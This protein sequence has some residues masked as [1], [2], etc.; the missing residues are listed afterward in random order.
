[1]ADQ[2]NGGGKRDVEDS[3]PVTE[4]ELQAEK[5]QEQ[6]RVRLRTTFNTQ[7][8]ALLRKNV[9]FQKR[10]WGTNICLVSM[11]ILM[12]VLLKII[13][14]AI[15][16]ILS[17]P[18]YR[19]G[20]VCT[21]TGQNN[22][23]SCPDP[24]QQTC[25]PQYS[26]NKQ[27]AFCAVPSP[28]MYPAMVQVPTQYYRAVQTQQ[29]NYPGLPDPS[30]RS[31]ANI[32]QSCPAIFLYT[33][34]NQTLA[35]AM[36][37]Y[38]TSPF[39]L[40]AWQSM[41]GV[42]I[43][44]GNPAS[45]PTPPPAAPAAPAATPPAP[46]GST[47]GMGGSGNATMYNGTV[48]L[49]PY[50]YNF[51]ALELGTNAS[52]TLTLIIEPAFMPVTDDPSKLYLLQP[53]CSSP[54]M[55][56]N[57]IS[58]SFDGF[59]REPLQLSCVPTSP[60]WRPSTAA[61][62]NELYNGFYQAQTALYGG[63]ASSNQYAGA[64]D[65]NTTTATRFNTTV[66]FNSSYAGSGGQGPQSAVRFPKAMNMAT[67]AYLQAVFSA[68]AELPLLFVKDFPKGSTAL[69]LDFASLI[70]P[71]FFM[72]ILLLLFPVCVGYLVYEKEKNL[73]MMMKMHGLGD[74]AYW[75]ISYA[76]FFL[77]SF[78]YILFFVLFG[79]LVGLKFFRIN[80][81]GLQ[82]IFYF[83]F[84]NW[85]I[86]FAILVATFFKFTKTA[87]V[88]AYLYVFGGG[89]LGQFLFGYFIEDPDFPA[90]AIFALQLIPPFACYRGLYEFSQSAFIGAYQAT[91][92]TLT[93]S[94]AGEYG[95][96]GA[97]GI[98]AV[99]WV[100][101]VLLG[102]YLDQVVPTGGG[103]GKHPLFFLDGIRGRHKHGNTL[104]R[105]SRSHRASAKGAVEA[106]KEREDVM[107]ERELVQQ[108][109][110][111][112]QL[113]HGYSIVCDNMR[114]VYPGRDGNPPKLAVRAM[115]LALARGECFGM[116]GPNGAGKT[117]C[118]HMMIGLVK[119]SSG[120][121]F[122]EG[123]DILEEMDD[124][125]TIMGV[126]PQH[127]L[128]WEQLTGREHLY[129]YGRLKN[130]HGQALQQAV[131]DSL[132]SVNLLAGGAADKKAGKYSGGMKRRLSVAISLIGKPPVV[133]MDEPSTGLD[134]A[135]RYNLWAV[136]K[137]AKKDSAIVLT[138]HS[139]EEA[140]A[141]CDQE[142][143]A[144][145]LAKSLSPNAKKVYS[146][147]GTQKFELPT[148]DVSFGDRLPGSSIR[149]STSAFFCHC[150][151]LLQSPS[152]LSSPS[153]PFLPS[154]PPSFPL[155]PLPSLSSPFLPSPPPSSLSSPSSLP[156]PP[157]LSSPFLR[158]LPLPPLSSLPPSPPPSSP[159]LP[160]L[161]S[162][163]PSSPLLPLPPLS[164]PF[165]P[166]PPLPPLSSPFPPSPPSSPLLPSPPS[167]PPPPP[168]STATCKSGP[169]PP[170]LPLAP[171][172]LL[173]LAPSSPTCR[174]SLCYQPPPLPT[175]P[176]PFLPL[177]GE[178]WRM[179]VQQ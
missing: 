150:N 161:P 36:G 77:L 98:M 107:A 86:A 174:T 133:Y 160:F 147:A 85:Q 20:C 37:A 122:I 68:A 9:T 105:A 162:P 108:L 51:A 110:Q 167:T 78:V 18:D 166:S 73:R 40:A 83:V 19:C 126:C 11:P 91:S 14:I 54:A 7:A 29:N 117:T 109:L 31:A 104:S 173:A 106:E 50:L 53:N 128:L 44:T 17:G 115:S 57:P 172:P 39:D 99:E 82:F 38:L 15:N 23:G 69:T 56:Q 87:S 89:L 74:S 13:E 93:F 95:F 124:V 171:P 28:Y 175:V 75:L 5:E 135:S 60:L 119:P 80:N 12:C 3:V 131:L 92:G 140:E 179:C 125:Y 102:L 76:Y 111:R 134:P 55:L 118:I 151:A 30:C 27:T 81:Y 8:N 6:R 169:P 143:A 62:D 113:D 170:L 114:K 1:M 35:N 123:K 21:A 138:T 100:I 154:P 97:V 149:L 34:Q 101:F 168:L 112:D 65:F 139:M 155:L 141:L 2:E 144:A 79:S 22:T 152:P 130:L 153:S 45:A 66:Y 165:L 48:G 64:F 4:Q 42:N 61:I 159:L 59:T 116:L 43:T 16:A 67:N 136:V 178:A 129:F 177:P 127:D 94:N 84:G 137:E 156:P 88:V 10:N 46:P 157:P 47:G 158:L 132:K 90:G 120:T 49:A 25:G 33:G 58:F 70:G 24:S 32:N 142:E 148:A 146:L 72:W 96:W 52:L 163:P 176:S 26:N 145:E 103:S 41:P 164:S 63:D 71:L 121:A